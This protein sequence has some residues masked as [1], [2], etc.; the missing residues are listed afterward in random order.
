M[1]NPEDTGYF[2][3]IAKIT[4]RRGFRLFL[5]R[6]VG[7]F[8]WFRRQLTADGKRRFVRDN[9]LIEHETLHVAG[10]FPANDSCYAH[11]TIRR[12]TPCLRIIPENT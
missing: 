3:Q 7:R 2:R 6:I 5:T 1:K 12:S 4:H 11:E 10:H 9:S 8:P